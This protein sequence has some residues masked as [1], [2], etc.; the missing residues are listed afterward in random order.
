MSK[1]QEHAGIQ[2][3]IYY[4]EDDEGNRVYDFEEM[5][6]EFEHKLSELDESVVVMCSVKVRTKDYEP[7]IKTFSELD[8]EVHEHPMGAGFAQKDVKHFADGFHEGN[9]EKD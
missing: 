7:E 2:I 8:K 4:Y 9:W 6:N 3:P 1:I 5:A